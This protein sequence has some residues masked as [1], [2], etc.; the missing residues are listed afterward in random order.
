MALSPSEGA[1]S[2]E[3]RPAAANDPGHLFRFQ[4]TLPLR[5]ALP[6]RGGGWPC[7]KAPPALSPLV[8][9]TESK[10][11]IYPAFSHIW[12]ALA[13][14]DN[15]DSAMS[16]TRR[17]Q[18]TGKF[19]RHM[20]HTQKRV[21]TQGN[22]ERTP[23]PHEDSRPW[24]GR[25]PTPSTSRPGGNWGPGGLWPARPARTTPGERHAED[26]ELVEGWK[27]AL[28]MGALNLARS[29]Q[30]APR[31]NSR[32]SRESANGENGEHGDALGRARRKPHEHG[33]RAQPPQDRT[34]S[35]G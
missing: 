1:V 3:T 35:T 12:G 19:K 27:P 33:L 10:A 24:A 29:G 23:S 32:F 14:T 17:V 11:G 26:T 31:P 8:T 7:A 21:C 16:L 6:G 15:G 28:E 20:T 2:I 9:G 18:A 22:Q 5:S 30:D 34:M 25:S 13:E 4:R